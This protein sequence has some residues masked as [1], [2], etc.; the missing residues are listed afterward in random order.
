MSQTTPLSIT[1]FAA[2]RFEHGVTRVVLNGAV[3]V[4][5]GTPLAFLGDPD[6]IETQIATNLAT[7]NT[8]RASLDL[9]LVR[10]RYAGRVIE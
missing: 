8:R 2:F 7:L 9:P 10:V 1:G 5:K 3:G 4:L 6:P